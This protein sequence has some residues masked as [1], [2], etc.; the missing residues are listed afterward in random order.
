MGT[1][2]YA[3]VEEIMFVTGIEDRGFV[4]RVLSLND[5]CANLVRKNERDEYCV[6]DFMSC[7]F[8]DVPIEHI[9]LVEDLIATNRLF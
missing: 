6:F 5:R 9:K 4:D 7:S 1:P 2:F 8:V 3:T